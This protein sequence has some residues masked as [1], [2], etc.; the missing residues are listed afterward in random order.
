MKKKEKLKREIEL[1]GNTNS[2]D[3][4]IN[5]INFSLQLNKEIISNL[6]DSNVVLTIVGGGKKSTKKKPCTRK[7]C[8]NSK[9]S[10]CTPGEKY[11]EDDFE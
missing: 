9:K 7:N 10:I 3:E 8:P 1:N 5:L 4:S 11:F 6:D 2:I